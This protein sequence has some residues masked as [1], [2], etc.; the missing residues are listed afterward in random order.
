VHI[1]YFDRPIVGW[2]PKGSPP[3]ANEKI[4]EPIFA[5]KKNRDCD[6]PQWIRLLREKYVDA[7]N[8]ALVEHYS[9]HPQENQRLYHPGSYADIGIANKSRQR[10]LGQKATALE[11]KGIPSKTGIYNVRSTLAEIEARE[12]RCL[13]R[14]TDLYAKLQRFLEKLQIASAVPHATTS[15]IKRL[16]ELLA[17]QSATI[18]K[19]LADIEEKAGNV[20]LANCAEIDPLYYA[21]S[22]E[23]LSHASRGAGFVTEKSPPPTYME[24]LISYLDSKGYHQAARALINE[25]VKLE[26]AENKDE[27]VRQRRI[28]TSLRLPVLRELELSVDEIEPLLSEWLKTNGDLRKA[29]KRNVAKSDRPQDS[30]SITESL[31]DNVQVNHTPAIKSSRLNN[32]QD[33]R[34]RDAR[35]HGRAYE[36][37]PTILDD[38]SNPGVASAIR[39]LVNS[40]SGYTRA[41]LSERDLKRFSVI[42]LKQLFVNRA[43]ASEANERASENE[44][45]RYELSL[46]KQEIDRRERGSPISKGLNPQDSKDPD[47]QEAPRRKPKRDSWDL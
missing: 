39:R 18:K 6:G 33:A 17:S 5:A 38:M 20:T 28:L 23:F 41:R 22:Q 9:Q 1:A 16:W 12:S 3:D 15:E 11:R 46:L 35:I 4:L 7:V 29:L 14:L 10:H 27:L 19:S 36:S 42:E 8:R 31:P 40:N 32:A 45:L 43:R 47:V 21:G 13:D 44:S 30:N 37:T 25:L 26:K 24:L 34:E 2:K